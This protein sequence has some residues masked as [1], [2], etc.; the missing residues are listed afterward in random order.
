MTSLK[1][2][3]S[4]LTGKSGPKL[5]TDEQLDALENN[6]EDAKKDIDKVNDEITSLRTKINSQ[7]RMTATP[8]V[9]HNEIDEIKSN[10]NAMDLYAESV[11]A[12]M[13]A[14]DEAGNEIR[15]T[16]GPKLNS[17]TQ[18]IFSHLTN[19][20]YSEILV[21]KNLEINTTEDKS[22]NIHTWQYLSAGTAEQAYFSLRL[23]IA[24]MI[25]QNKIPL[26]LDDVFIQYDPGRAKK[27][28]EFISEYSR[29]NQVL[30]FTCHKYEEFSDKY[31]MFPES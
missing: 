16:F 8:A 3:L 19:G 18:R 6:L 27:G 14:L 31:I 10:I 13:E 24:D 23:A 11:K 9:I 1:N 5:L 22:S 30:L 29:L 2:K 7:Y 21:S 15:Q 26:F 12:A 4:T 17:H 20:K 25:T 28:F